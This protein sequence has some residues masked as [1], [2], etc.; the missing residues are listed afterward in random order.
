VTTVRAYGLALGKHLHGHNSNKQLASKWWTES[1]GDGFVMIKLMYDYMAANLHGDQAQIIIQEATHELLGKKFDL[2]ES[3]NVHAY[4]SAMR[5]FFTVLKHANI[6]ADD[7]KLFTILF[8]FVQGWSIEL[9]KP[10]LGALE[11]N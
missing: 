1:S 6:K 5:R 4:R 8:S 3:N 10:I 7:E 2:E 9:S 11:A